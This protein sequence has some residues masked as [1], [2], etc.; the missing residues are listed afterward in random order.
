M[1][2]I[3]LDHAATT[4]VL[5]E[6]VQFME[7]Y[8][9]ASF[10]NASSVH[11]FGR[12]A[13]AGVDY[14]KTQLAKLFGCHEKEVLCTGGATESNNL[15]L[16]GLVAAFRAYDPKRPIHIVTTAIEHPSVLESARAL[17]REGVA[18]TVVPVDASGRVSAEAVRDAITDDTILV[19][20]MYVN[21]ETGVVQPVRDIGKAVER[22]NELR[23]KAK[24]RRRESPKLSAYERVYMHTDAVQ[25]A[26]WFELNAD[27]LHVD[28]M[29]IS[30]HKFG[31]PKGAGALYVRTGVP[32][33]TL[34]YGGKQEYGI[35]PGTYNV[36]AIVG[37]GRAVEE[38]KEEEMKRWSDRVKQMRDEMLQKLQDGIPGLE[39]NGSM[40]YRAPNTI[41]ISIPGLDGENAL[42]ALDLAGVAVSTGA[43][44][45]SASIEPSHVLIAMGFDAVRCR[46]SLR[47]SLGT[48]TTPEECDAAAQAIFTVARRA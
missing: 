45:A 1:R 35:R 16:R 39:V 41:N 43:A 46:G 25:A 12:E 48:G 14:A 19:S 33:H 44:C 13:R 47:I 5:P 3:Y 30:A 28:L 8:H 24:E 40:E 7:P 20:V 10:G 32:M 11:S 17:E 34:S 18:L 6:V 2:R 22:A 29:T 36:P 38:L 37:M 42:I 4:P 15:A 9:T 26:R 23:S 31:G 27:H 21:N